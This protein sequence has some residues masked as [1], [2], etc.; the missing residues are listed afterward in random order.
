MELLEAGKGRVLRD[1][2]DVAVV[3]FGHEGEE[4]GLFGEGE[5]P[6]V[7]EQGSDDMI[8]VV[9]FLGFDDRG[10]FGSRVVHICL[11]LVFNSSI[12]WVTSI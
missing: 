4:E 9:P 2:G 8:S 6:A 10:N 12:S 11:I 7:G 3:S 1:G 5:R